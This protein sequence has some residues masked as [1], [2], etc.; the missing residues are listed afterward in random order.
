MLAHALRDEI[1]T[2]GVDVLDLCTGS[3]A[4]AVSAAMLGA[5]TTAV[6]VSRRALISARLNARLNGVRVRTRRGWL[7]EAL[8]GERFDVIASN[9]PYLP[10][11]PLLPHDGPARAWEGGLDGRVLLD[12]ICEQAASFLRP[13]GAVL[14]VHSSVCG[15]ERT[16]ALLASTGLEV[17][18]VQ[19]T[20]G[21]LGARLRERA[22]DLWAAG[23]LAPGQ[24]EEDIV[25]V[26]GV[27]PAVRRPVR[28]VTARA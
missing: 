9:P 12:P 7:F 3:G 2:A 16:L 25:I 17:G 21:P 5:R 27:L 8:R 4:L 13:G 14:L 20:R 26:R 22:S 18:V 15:V 1:A 11:A 23:L 24:L 6:D 10:G 28:Q 19:R